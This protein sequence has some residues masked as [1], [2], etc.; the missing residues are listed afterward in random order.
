MVP[1]EFPK[2]GF[3]GTFEVP[4]P[5]TQTFNEMWQALRTSCLPWWSLLVATLVLHHWEE[6]IFHGTAANEGLE[7]NNEILNT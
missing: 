5:V 6:K 2:Q 7:M 3:D 4:V 1:L